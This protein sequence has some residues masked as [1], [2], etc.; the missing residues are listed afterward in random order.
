MLA[1]YCPPSI[2]EKRNNAELFIPFPNGSILY[3]LGAN[4][5]ASLRGPNPRGVVLDEYGD[6]KSDVWPGIV[7]PIMTANPEGWTWFVGT[8][9]GT[10][11][12]YKKYL[13]AKSGESKQ[14]FLSYLKASESGILPA[15]ALAETR[16]EAPEAFYQQEYEVQWLSGA[17]QFF[18]RVRENV[19]EGRLLLDPSHLY[20]IGVDLAK[21][22]DWTVLSP[23]DLN[24]FKAH[25]QDRFNQVDWNLQ[26][27]KIEAAHHRYNRAR[28]VVDSTGVGDPIVEDLTRSGVVV[29][30]EDAFKF[31]ES[32]RLQLLKHLAILLES[33]RIKI[34]N[35]EGLIEELESF[36]YELTERGKVRVAVPEGLHDDRVMALA[37]SVWGNHE[38][39]TLTLATGEQR[40]GERKEA[41]D[42]YKAI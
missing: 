20:Q 11:D 8:P 29:S 40:Y 30:E 10:N 2:W 6:M 34:P 14:W 17:A 26:R 24:T 16:K 31:T 37:L 22:Q 18:Q 41:F 32:S 5:P 25:H 21:Y 27:A 28:T 12:F 15:E 7:Q 36:R 33:D 9:R 1:K 13:Y 38:P 35:D 4:Y 3:V 39:T 23:F 19:Y 42:P